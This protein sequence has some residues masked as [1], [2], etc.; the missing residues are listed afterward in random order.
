[1]LTLKN[2]MN[3]GDSLLNEHLG[4]RLVFTSQWLMSYKQYDGVM[5]HFDN[6]GE[7]IQRTVTQGFYE[8]FVAVRDYAKDHGFADTWQVTNQ[9]PM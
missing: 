5:T 6:Q 8:T 9:L 7:Q 3:M 2:A 1:M 4:E